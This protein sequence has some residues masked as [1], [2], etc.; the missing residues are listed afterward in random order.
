MYLKSS[1]AVVLLFHWIRLNFTVR[2]FT[3]PAEWHLQYVQCVCVCTK[4]TLHQ[5][6]TQKRARKI[7]T[8]VLRTPTTKHWLWKVM[9][10]P[11]RPHLLDAAA[12][13]RYVTVTSRAFVEWIFSGSSLLVASERFSAPYAGRPVCWF[14]WVTELITKPVRR[15]DNEW[16]QNIDRVK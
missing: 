14:E 12:Q 4:R 6:T 3:W 2:G 11:W 10:G 15:K 16:T 13:L 5:Y 7:R 1:R 8:H 9:R